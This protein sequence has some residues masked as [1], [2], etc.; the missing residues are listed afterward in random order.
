MPR[1][2]MV[3]ALFAVVGAIASVGVGL[4][5]FD[6]GLAKSAPVAASPSPVA[7]SPSPAAVTPSPVSPEPT[8]TR[9]HTRGL[10]IGEAN[11]V[12]SVKDMLYNNYGYALPQSDRKIAARGR[13]ACRRLG[14]NPTTAEIIFEARIT[15]PVLRVPPRLGFVVLAALHW[16][17]C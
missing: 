14:K 9:A 13:A 8:E 12:Q 15:S 1:Y 7:V 11:A 6:S 16:A 2:T 3:A 4:R 10:A 5:L 17:F